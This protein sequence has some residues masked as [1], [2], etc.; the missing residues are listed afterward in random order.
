MF[1]FACHVSICHSIDQLLVQ[2]SAVF[3]I[4]TL[5]VAKLVVVLPEPQ[6]GVAGFH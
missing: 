1:D 4:K 3:E 6:T 2:G 5:L